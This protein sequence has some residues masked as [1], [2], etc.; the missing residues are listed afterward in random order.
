MVAVVAARENVWPMRNWSLCGKLGGGPPRAT[1]EGLRFLSGVKMRPRT[2]ETGRGGLAWGVVRARRVRGAGGPPRT[3]DV[4]C[5]L[6][7]EDRAA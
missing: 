4:L 3:P 5:L 2:S 6:R 1:T 7:T